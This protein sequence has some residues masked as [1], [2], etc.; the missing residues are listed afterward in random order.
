MK[1]AQ[2]KIDFACRHGFFR[3]F[4]IACCVLISFF[5]IHCILVTM[6]LKNVSPLL[7]HCFLL[8]NDTLQA[9]YT[10]LTSEPMD[11]G[12][13]DSPNIGMGHCSIFMTF[14]QWFRIYLSI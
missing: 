13:A 12:S 5:E 14:C 4:Y 9:T 11:Y 1:E 8:Y 7:L 3:V 10:L 6:F 2:C